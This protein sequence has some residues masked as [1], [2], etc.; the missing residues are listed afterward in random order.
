MATPLNS[1][2]FT[3]W[4]QLDILEAITKRFIFDGIRACNEEFSPG[5]S[6]F[7]VVVSGRHLRDLYSQTAGYAM[8]SGP[9]V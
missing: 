9:Q 2:A 1:V 4:R 8:R 6:L 3:V 5:K 7:S